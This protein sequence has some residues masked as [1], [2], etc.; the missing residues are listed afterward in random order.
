MTG[1]DQ[2][3]SAPSQERRQS[4]RHPWSVRCDEPADRRVRSPVPVA[5]R[6]R[7]PRFP[8]MGSG[9]SLMAGPRRQ[10]RVGNNPLEGHARANTVAGRSLGHESHGTPSTSRSDSRTRGLPS[11][12]Q[13]HYTGLRL[14]SWPASTEAA[15]QVARR[16]ASSVTG[17]SGHQG[18]VLRRCR[19]TSRRRL[20]PAPHAPRPARH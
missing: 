3:L 19:S 5:A 15:A 4:T 18:P 10:P 9:A 16:Q 6:S 8:G 17:V 14:E 2:S 1:R 11:V 20:T 7:R 12:L 13:V